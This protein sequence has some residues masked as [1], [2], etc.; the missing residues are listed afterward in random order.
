MKI[1]SSI[2]IAA[3]VSSCGFLDRDS[4]NS[5]SDRGTVQP[6]NF[7]LTE[8]TVLDANA[9]RAKV[10]NLTFLA[11]LDIATQSAKDL[12]STI[13]RGKSPTLRNVSKQN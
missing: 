1:L 8:V 3:I 5:P 9:I 4:D 2:A 11:K 13:S 6:P 10:N 12:A 7:S